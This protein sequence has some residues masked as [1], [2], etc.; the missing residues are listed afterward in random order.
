[1]PVVCGGMTQR[2]RLTIVA[3]ACVVVVAIVFRSWIVA[4]VDAAI[5]LTTALQVPIASPLVRAL[6]DEPIRSH[7]VRVGRATTTVHAPP[8]GGSRP[9]IVLVSGFDT[10]STADPLATRTADGLARA[11]YVVV[12]TG[13]PV[14]TVAADQGPVEQMAGVLRATAERDDVDVDR[15]SMLASS[16]GAGVGLIAAAQQGD[17]GGS[18]LRAIVALAPYVDLRNV[19]LQVTTDHYRDADGSFVQAE[20]E[21]V[22]RETVRRLVGQALAM[23]DDD[24][25]LVSTLEQLGVDTSDPLA[26]LAHVPRDLLPADVAA[27]A[28]LVAN[29][30]PERFDELYGEL[31]QYMRQTVDALSPI[32]HADQ[33]DTRVELAASPADPHLPLAEVRRLADELPDSRLTVTDAVDTAGAD[34]GLG[35]GDLWK[36][37]AL[38]VRFLHRAQRPTRDQK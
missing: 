7:D 27:L 20:A 13:A 35:V 12:V 15:V 9:V 2:R 33:V 6:T 18:E 37:N 5:V 17:E 28:A 34:D 16:I 26:A 4:Q 19:L 38:F 11:G 10:D 29:D 31:P 8:G 30:D 23:E 24:G 32:E 21:P 25:S 1:M 22:V 14:S 3:L 36:M